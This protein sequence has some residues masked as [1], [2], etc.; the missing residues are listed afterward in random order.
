MNRVG[1]RIGITGGIGSGKTV[2]S[3]LLNVLG[4]PVYISDEEA[5]RLMNTDPCIRE[6]LIHLL[7]EEVYKEGILNRAFLADYLFHSP[8]HA[9]KVNAI[10][11][12]Q[13]KAD[14]L[15]WV[16]RQ[17]SSVVAIESAILYEAGFTDT[18]DV[19]V[20]VYA[21][22]ELRVERALKRDKTTIDQI[23]RR[24]ASQMSDEQKREQADYVIY[25]DDRHSLIAQ[26]QKL[27]SVLPKP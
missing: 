23:R 13:V 24:V 25:N 3:R 16:K 21:P 20:L 19:V 18:V 5:K 10:V 26:V 6:Q 14:F 27:L 22:Q 12:P 2:V 7:G 9:A 4:V 15:A 8:D 17:Q 11:H 1:I